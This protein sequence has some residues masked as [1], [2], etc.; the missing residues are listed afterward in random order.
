MVIVLFPIKHA[1]NGFDALKVMIL[2]WRTKSVLWT[3]KSIWRR[4]IAG[5]GGWRPMSNAKTT[6]KSIKLYSICYFWSFE[7]LG[8]DLQGKWVPYKLKSRDI[9]SRKTICEILLGNKEKGFCTELWLAMKSESISIIP[10]AEKCAIKPSTLTP[11]RNIYG[12][13][14]MLC[15]W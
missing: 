4:R 5:I 11:K 10:N 9:E 8:R 7:S 13:K 2:M 1:E 3:A 15:I 12:K 6:C 14:A